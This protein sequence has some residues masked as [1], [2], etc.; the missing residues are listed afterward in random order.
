MRTSIALATYQGGRFLRQQL[1]S[2]L[3]QTRLPDE[4]CISDDGSTDETVDVVRDFSSTAPFS[5]KLLVNPERGG[6]NKNFENA[7]VHCTGDV[8]LF[9]DQDDIWLPPHLE[10]LVAPME[11]DPRITAV[12]SDSQFVDENLE[13]VGSTQAQS[14]RF[15]PALRAATMRLGRNQFELVLRQN[16]ATGHGM[17]FRRR[18]LPL[19]APFT[20]TFLFDEWVFVLAAAAGFITYVPE[21]LT[22][23]RQH[24]HQTLGARNKDLQLWASQ[25]KNVSKEQ[26]RVQEEKWREMLDRVRDRRDSLADPQSAEN[27][28]QEKLDFIVR[29]TRTRRRPL[30]MRL[31]LTTRELL[32]GRYHR[33]GRGWLAFARDLYGVRGR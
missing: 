31:L 28:L 16:I 1:D 29:R 11:L 25:S 15:S 6:V 2:F 8:I 32:L 4:L 5:V 12:A 9:S 30:P 13:P 10:R 20:G 22:L 17:A 23:H 24:G 14:D 26:E 33:L 18:L 3:N 7:A 21:P 19:L 27:A